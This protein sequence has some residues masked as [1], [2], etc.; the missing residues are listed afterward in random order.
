[1]SRL[2]RGCVGLAWLLLIASCACAQSPATGRPI[3]FVH[4]WC[5]DAAGWSPLQ[6]D[7]TRDLTLLPQS[8]YSGLNNTTLTLYYDS[9]SDSVKLFPS[10]QDLLTSGISPSRRFFSINFY[11]ADA[12]SSTSVDT[13]HVCDVSI[14]NKA[15]ELAQVIH[16]ITTLTHIT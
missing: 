11:A 14:L 1:M 6:E 12:F 3:L 16:A 10:G 7:V 8:P 4:G 13:T 5:G 9:A 15:D 2:I